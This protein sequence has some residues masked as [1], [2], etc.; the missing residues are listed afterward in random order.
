MELNLYCLLDN[1][2]HASGFH[3]QDPGVLKL[4]TVMQ[5]YAVLGHG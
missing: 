4:D 2:F 3:S 5:A 1:V